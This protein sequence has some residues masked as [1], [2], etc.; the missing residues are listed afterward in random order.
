MQGCNPSAARCAGW[1][2]PYLDRMMPGRDAVAG[3]ILCGVKLLSGLPSGRNAPNPCL[4]RY[5]GVKVHTTASSNP[6]SAALW[7]DCW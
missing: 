6:L 3:I 2:Q 5:H 7:R 4:Q 1:R